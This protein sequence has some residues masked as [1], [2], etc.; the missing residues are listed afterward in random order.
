MKRTWSFLPGPWILIEETA[1]MK[2]NRKRNIS[3]CRLGNGSGRN[4]QG[5]LKSDDKGIT[6]AVESDFLSFGWSEKRRLWGQGQF[7]LRPRG[8]EGGTLCESGK[9]EWACPK[10]LGLQGAYS[11]RGTKRSA[12][13]DHPALCTFFCFGIYQN[14]IKLAIYV[15]ISLNLGF[16]YLKDT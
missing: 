12:C 11:N 13:I 14:V 1:K 9:T 10:I 4:L 8:G 3:N 2:M 5:R 16:E 15:Y 6:T 7:Q